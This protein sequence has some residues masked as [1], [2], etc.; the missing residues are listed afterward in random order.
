MPVVFKKR[1]G[2]SI[3]LSENKERL[4][5]SVDQINTLSDIVKNY[6]DY[7]WKE[8]T[9]LFNKSCK[10]NR[11]QNSLEN[12]YYE[13]K[14]IQKKAL[15]NVLQ[16]PCVSSMNVLQVPCVSGMNVLQNNKVVCEKI[17]NMKYMYSQKAPD[18]SPELYKK[19]CMEYKYPVEII[20]G[21]IDAPQQLE[22]AAR[23]FMKFMTGET[24]EEKK[25]KYQKETT[26]GGDVVGETFIGQC[27]YHCDGV[28]GE[29]IRKFY[30]TIVDS[31]KK[32]YF[33]ANSYKNVQPMYEVNMKNIHLFD[34]F[35]DIIDNNL[36]WRFRPV[37]AED[38]IRQC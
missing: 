24:I 18:Y 38:I 9:E 4:R 34:L 31:N 33:F 6:P 32:L 14:K 2:D 5:W 25:G 1:K 28:A 30:G 8:K 26:P 22:N 3:R 10:T 23:N 12:R 35:N 15:S 11:T 21:T 17:E 36:Y 19:F 13:I 7:S 20:N 29:H 37:N 27:K 16:V